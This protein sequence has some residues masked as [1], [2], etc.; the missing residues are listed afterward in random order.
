MDEER[1]EAAARNLAG[2]KG[3][4]ED[5]RNFRARGS[6]EHGRVASALLRMAFG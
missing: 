4:Q 1:L 2:E 5:K 6:A 3:E